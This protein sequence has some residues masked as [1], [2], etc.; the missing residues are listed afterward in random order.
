MLHDRLPTDGTTWTVSKSPVDTKK[1]GSCSLGRS[2]SLAPDDAMVD[3]KGQA[4]AEKYLVLCF[5]VICAP[6]W[7]VGYLQQDFSVPFRAWVAATL[8]AALVRPAAPS[9]AFACHHSPS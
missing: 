5:V 3:Y 2:L 9:C 7:V 6:A 1:T 4:L 8:L